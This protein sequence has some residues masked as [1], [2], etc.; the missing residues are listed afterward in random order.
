MAETTKAP[1]RQGGALL[2]ADSAERLGGFFALPVIG[3]LAVAGAIGLARLGRRIAEV[4]VGA[5]GI[6]HGPHASASRGSRH[7]GAP[8][9]LWF[10]LDLSGRRRPARQA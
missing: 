5:L 1:S 6:A 10:H 4:E 9:R 3:R 8:R 2:L 7:Q